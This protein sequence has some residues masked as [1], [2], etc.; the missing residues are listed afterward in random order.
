MRHN[1]VEQPMVSLVDI[2]AS[3]K[4]S[5]PQS[6]NSVLTEDVIMETVARH[7]DIPFLKIDPLD[8]DS[9]VVTQ[10]ISRPYAVRNQ[11]VPIALSNN[12]LTVATAN[13]FEM[14]AIDR[15]ERITGFTVK[16]VVTTKSD[17]IR[18][19][20]PGPISATLNST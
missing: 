5:S 10:T 4:L 12:T 17:I 18:K 13:P 9:D 8:L 7:L 19:S 16:V 1:I 11:L 14:E 15:I 20:I 2:I 6:K 3:L